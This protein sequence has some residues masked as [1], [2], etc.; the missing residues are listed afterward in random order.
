LGLDVVTEDVTPSA[1]YRQTT[2]LGMLL[3]TT[4]SQCPEALSFRNQNFGPTTRSSFSSS[5]D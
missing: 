1:Y 3:S 5:P 2:Y 4:A